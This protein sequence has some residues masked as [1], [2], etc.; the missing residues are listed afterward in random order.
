[1]FK[2]F[3][4]LFFSFFT[5]WNVL[6]QAVEES[7]VW[8]YQIWVNKWRWAEAARNLI[9]DI[10][11]NIML[12]IVISIALI[13]WI[14]SFYKLKLSTNTDD[15]KKSAQWLMWWMFWIILMV[16]A[17]FI[18]SNLI[19][20]QWDLNVRTWW[21]LAVTIYNNIIFPFLRLGL[22][23]VSS[24]LFI[25]LIIHARKMII[26]KEDVKNKARTIVIRN[27]L[28]ILL[29]LWASYLVEIIYWRIQWWNI[30]PTDLWW[31]AQWA[32]ANKKF[33]SFLWTSINYLMAFTAIA[34]IVIIIYQSYK[35][36]LNPEDEWNYK[37]LRRSIVYIFIWMLI[38][39]SWYLIA[40]FIIIK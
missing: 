30:N 18:V 13:L 27:S 28:G 26:S 29:L 40:N 17:I 25:I 35:L 21:N 37:S 33:I 36:L 4:F 19:T 10:A 15:M 38:L 14:F 39:F 34:I 20:Q 2:I 9:I 31:I 12:P 7:W 24:F 22:F 3:V 32:F 1:M 6:D 8:F 11:R 16:S 5:F 23:F